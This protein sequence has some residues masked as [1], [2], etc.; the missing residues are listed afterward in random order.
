MPPRC[1][2]TCVGQWAGGRWPGPCPPEKAQTRWG[3]WGRPG[4]PG[5][6][7][8]P[9]ALSSSH[10]LT[11]QT[12][13]TDPTSLGW[14]KPLAHRQGSG[15]EAHVTSGTSL[16]SGTPPR[17]AGFRQRRRNPQPRSGSSGLTAG[18][19][20]VRGRQCPPWRPPRDSVLIQVARTSPARPPPPPQWNRAG[21]P[22][23]RCGG[24]GRWRGKCRGWQAGGPGGGGWVRARPGPQPR[25]IGHLGSPSPACAPPACGRAELPALTAPG[26]HARACDTET[27][28]RTLHPG[29]FQRA[30]TPLLQRCFILPKKIWFF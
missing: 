6:G 5:A 23:R 26:V 27:D 1:A 17:A 13:F 21:G 14:D 30:E 15:Q 24:G 18:A 3:P 25:P 10:P 16:R 7:A 9:G 2:P 22:P 29:R 11:T 19:G 12:V 4:R 28:T 8:H 20:A